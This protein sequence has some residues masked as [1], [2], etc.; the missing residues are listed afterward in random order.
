MGDPTTRPR[1]EPTPARDDGRRPIIPPV[2][3]CPPLPAAA[4]RCLGRPSSVC[5]LPAAAAR[6]ASQ[7]ELTQKQAAIEAR[8]QQ[9]SAMLEDMQARRRRRACAL[10]CCVVIRSIIVSMCA[11]AATRT[12]QRAGRAGPNLVPTLSSIAKHQDTTTHP[13]PSTRSLPGRAHVRR[14]SSS[15]PADLYIYI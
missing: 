6:R 5:R 11:H 12:L 4:R 2:C 9:M 1:V 10:R 7:A 14:R 15:P 3:R 13:S 8:Q